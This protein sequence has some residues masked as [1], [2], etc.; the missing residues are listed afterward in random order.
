MEN[1]ERST[2]SVVFLGDPQRAAGVSW[3]APRKHAESFGW[4]SRQRTQSHECYRSACSSH[5][6]RNRPI[7]KKAGTMF[8]LASM[9]CVGGA[10][11]HFYRRR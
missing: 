5:T 6:P 3:F 1:R 4:P 11:D 7:G 9:K 2:R 8:E 10:P